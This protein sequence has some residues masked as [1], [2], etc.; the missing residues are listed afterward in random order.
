M[1]IGPVVS[2]ATGKR[3]IA[4]EILG[5]PLAVSLES[6]RPYDVSAGRRLL[7]RALPELG[8]AGDVLAN[9]GFGKMASR[10]GLNLRL[11]ADARALHRSLES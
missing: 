11:H 8:T 3:S 7:A 4:I 6:A 10:N 9:R 1:T 5:L 2:G